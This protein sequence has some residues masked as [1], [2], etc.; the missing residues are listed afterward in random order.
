MHFSDLKKLLLKLTLLGIP[1]YAVCLYTAVFPF[2]YMP[3]EYSMWRQ[4]RD[5]VDTP[6]EGDSP[7]TLV[8]GDSR[9]KSGIIPKLLSDGDDAY[10]IAIG[11]CGPVEMYYALNDYLACHET[12]EDMIV[13]FA[14]YHFCDIDN[15]GQTMTFN[16]LGT[17]RLLSV[18]GSA[19]GCG[20]SE[21]LGEHFFSDL[22]SCK[23]RLPNKYL[24][25]L[26]AAFEE[27]RGLRNREKYASVEED[28]GYTVFGE[29]EGNDGLC[30]EVHH[31]DFD[32]SVLVMDYYKKMLDIADEAGIR[33][34]IIQSPVNE[35][36]AREISE[37]FR[38][39]YTGLMEDIGREHPAFVVETQI[40]TYENRFFGDNNH[41]NNAGAQ[42]FTKEVRDRYFN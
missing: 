38:S 31:P 3:V 15:W 9:A 4:E 2:S 1:L 7:R 10:N 19:A 37:E 24:S 30:Y 20:E 41:L 39:G 33:V 40:P 22:L 42:V 29:E 8:I 14:P 13:I 34:Y 25:S 17:S 16:Y 26:Y 11:G 23:L 21:M 35:A 5:F 28:S 18:F 12:P 32:S 36:S 6:M 27:K